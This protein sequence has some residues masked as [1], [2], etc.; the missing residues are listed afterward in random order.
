MNDTEKN[1][2]SI[3]GNDD[4]YLQSRLD[5]IL[6]QQYGQMYKGLG[7]ERR[8]KLNA[9][10]NKAMNAL[11]GA[12][13]FMG[14]AFGAS[15]Y[16]NT[17][18]DIMRD[19]GTTYH[20][21]NGVGYQKYND[22]NEAQYM[23]DEHKGNVNN[24]LGLMASGATAGAAFGP[25]GAAIGGVVGL[26]AGLFGA[27]K[28]HAEARKTLALAQDN[29]MRSDM[30]SY[31]HAA[32]QAG[33]AD[34]RQKYR[35]YE[36][37]PLLGANGIDTMGETNAIVKPQEKK[38]TADGF[39]YHEGNGYS[40][41]DNVAEHLEPG[42]KIITDK[43][44]LAA[45]ADP[46]IRIQQALR[47]QID[48]NKGNNHKIAENAAKK[49]LNETQEQ[50][51][52]IADK[53]HQLR[54]QGYLPPEG[55]PDYTG[56]AHA[57]SGLEWGN[58]LAGVTG[59]LVGLGQYLGAKGQRVKSPN[60]YVRNPYSQRAF[61]MLNGLR[62]NSK[63]ILDQI[64]REGANGRY[65]INTAGGL[66]GAQKYLANVAMVNNSQVAKANALA[67]IQQQNNAYTSAAAQAYLT[68]GAQEA[69]NRIQTNQW[70]LDYYSKAHAAR[71]QGMQMGLYNSLNNLQQ[72]IAN[73]NKLAMFGNMYKLYAQDVNN[74]T[75][76]LRNGK[77][78]A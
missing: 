72:Y 67:N 3:Y 22:I 23:H 30:F 60:T 71:Q 74:K 44:G 59:G 47:A 68:S 70:D 51:L 65:R 53:Q 77:P 29:T 8:D 43:F 32:T 58:L 52:A 6:N 2:R 21:V 56:V 61:D 63:P 34:F 66:S 55:T 17:A 24:T 62:I 5:D 13:S 9:F 64:D 1:L 39:G 25:W 37:M 41:V 75:W 16:E 46:I 38:V 40:P 4:P 28:R 14:Q 57:A 78:Y 31:A 11:P 36:N 15:Q 18:A 27:G 10:G 20:S 49:A 33:R 26:G 45:M 76:A 48:K 73:A 35:N 69:G 50:L 12:V 42:D 19:A 7:I 54:E